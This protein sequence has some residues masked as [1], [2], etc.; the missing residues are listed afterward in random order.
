M[1]LKALRDAPGVAVCDAEW[2]V[3]ERATRE[4]LRLGVLVSPGPLQT[5]NRQLDGLKHRGSRAA[6]T[7]AIHRIDKPGG[8]VYTIGV[9]ARFEV[10]KKG[11]RRA[12][13]TLEGSH[14]SIDCVMW[15]DS[16]DRAEAYGRLPAVGD[17]VGVEG[18]VKQTVVSRRFDDDKPDDATLDIEPSLE[19][20]VNQVW[21]GNIDDSPSETD[22]GSR[23][24]LP[25]A[26]APG[27]VP[28]T[29]QPEAVP[30][31]RG[32]V[33]AAALA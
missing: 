12:Y 19:L 28:S 8:C 2:G 29:T 31:Q 26:G 32:P 17:I 23:S 18:K 11:A 30:T 4:R 3:D 9:V 33:I 14:A 27:A 13:L 21:V 6:Q 25:L 15:A 24:W 5:V 20:V 1:A 7:V 10:A 22:G 16:L